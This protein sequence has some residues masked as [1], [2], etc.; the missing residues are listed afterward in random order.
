MVDWYRQTAWNKEIEEFFF[1]KLARARKESRAQYLKIQAIELIGTKQL[2]LLDAAEM[3]IQKLFNDYPDNRIDRSA[4]LNALG[5]IYKLK[6]NL[7]LSLDYY[8]RALDY[9][10]IFPNVITH[11]YL[12]FA[13][14][15]IKL[16]KE[17]FYSIAESTILN[18]KGPDSP[19]PIERYES[20]SFLSII[21]F[22][23][24]DHNKA[25]DFADLA[26]L[27]ASAKI[28][29]FRNHKNLGVVAKREIWIDD[30]VAYYKIESN[31]DKK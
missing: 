16:K 19:F 6:G 29:D 8:K 12:Y 24:G 21:N 20:Y 31:R 27:S 10:E 30:L 3:L 9:E 5:D 13:E 11:A 15:V 23:K 2:T 14:L 17:E 18:R 1:K 28:S 25:F 4:S 22:L 7:I 26:E